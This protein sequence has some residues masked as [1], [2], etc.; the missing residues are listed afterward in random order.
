MK[1]HLADSNS[2]FTTIQAART[3]YDSFNENTDHNADINLLKRLAKKGH[4]SVFE[5]KVLTFSIRG[6]SRACLQ[7]LVR[8]R[9]ASFSVK[10]TRYTLR[11]LLKI[12]EYEEFEQ[13]L[14]PANGF[15]PHQLSVAA[16]C[17]IKYQLEQG[18]SND[19][20]KSLLPESFK[21]DL[22]MTINIRSLMNFFQLR[23]AE[24]AYWEIRLLAQKMYQTLDSISQIIW[25][26]WDTPKR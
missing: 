19:E 25:T 26:E 14:V 24:G 12:S 6:I 7:E 4:H 21:T 16:L 8:H 10:S 1:V 22:M 3:C 17:E 15:K 20:V 9:M 18:L 11:E 23:L 5:H 2:W 13:F